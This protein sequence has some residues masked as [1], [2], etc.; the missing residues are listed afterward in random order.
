MSFLVNLSVLFGQSIN[1]LG[2]REVK[3]HTYS[4]NTSNAKWSVV[5]LHFQRAVRPP[6][7]AV[8][9]RELHLSFGVEA[10]IC[11]ALL[12]SQI[13]PMKIIFIHPH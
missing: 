12:S 7:T 6:H 13:F 9:T 10:I 4:S 8:H 11:A 5:D 1:I 3:T 2:G